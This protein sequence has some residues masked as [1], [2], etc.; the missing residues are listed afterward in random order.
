MMHYLTRAHLFIVASIVV[1]LPM[2]A[3]ADALEI[4]DGWVAAAPAV[5]KTQAVYFTLNN[6]GDKDVVITTVSA[7]G[8]GSAMIH[9]TMQHG[10][11]TMMHM[12]STLT[13]PAHQSVVLAPGGTHVMLMD[14]GHIARSGEKVQ[15]TLG[16]KDGSKQ[17]T[18]LDVKNPEPMSLSEPANPSAAPEHSH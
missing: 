3:Q 4:R 2:V 10:D 1:L 5:A 16:F 18:E 12:L 6:P 15:L 14:P 11:M 17:T 7:K 13:V 8:F 9:M